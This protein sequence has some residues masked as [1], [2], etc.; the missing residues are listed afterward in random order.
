MQH[1]KPKSC[2]LSLM[3]Y[4]QVN[5]SPPFPPPPL[6]PLPS[7][8]VSVS[9]NLWSFCNTRQH[10]GRAGDMDESIRAN[11]K[12][13]ERAKTLATHC[14]WLAFSFSFYFFV[15]VIFT[16]GN[17]FNFQWFCVNKIRLIWLSVHSCRH[18]I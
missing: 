2:H 17:S 6:P 15:L 10:W 8:T 11:S 1:N 5:P 16:N 13:V 14:I 9:W 4:L 12:E 3:G 18:D 7:L